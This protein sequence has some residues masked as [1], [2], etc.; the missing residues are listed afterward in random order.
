MRVYV[1]VYVCVRVCRVEC[2]HSADAAYFL[3]EGGK[4]EDKKK[5]GKN[6][7]SSKILMAE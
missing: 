1:C 6:R 5:E 7:Y 3:P 2:N 4:R